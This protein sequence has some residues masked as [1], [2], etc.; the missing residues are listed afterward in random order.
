MSEIQQLLTTYNDLEEEMKRF[1][2]LVKEVMTSVSMHEFVPEKLNQEMMQSIMELDT[3]QKKCMKQYKEADL[4]DTPPKKMSIMRDQIEKRM[5]ED[6]KVEYLEAIKSSFLSLYAEDADV[7]SKL[8]S[9]KEKIQTIN[10]DKYPLEKCLVYIRPFAVFLTMIKSDD[11]V[12]AIE[13]VPVLNDYFG[14]ALVAH[15]TIS[16]DIKLGEGAADFTLDGEDSDQ[17]KDSAVED[18]SVQSAE[19][20]ED[21]ADTAEQ[22]PVEEPADVEEVEEVEEVVEEDTEEETEV[23]E[24]DTEAEADVEEDFA[25]EEEAEE[26]EAP[27]AQAEEVEEAPASKPSKPKKPKK[28][29]LKALLAEDNFKESKLDDQELKDMEE[30]R[31]QG[32]KGKRDSSFLKLKT[33]GSLGG[34]F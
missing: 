25:E 24:D 26:V 8:E 29:D 23:A 12:K 10:T 20:V 16:K 11:P 7:D 6:R 22:I 14:S 15:I 9:F 4:G 21:E 5:N 31:K 28:V 3:K 32:K 1:S 19:S 27:V 34:R 17:F 30:A 2:S 18:K 13:Q 33:T